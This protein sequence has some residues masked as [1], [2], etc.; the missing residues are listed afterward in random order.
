MEGEGECK[1]NVNRHDK[2][3]IENSLGIKKVPELT[4][5][6]NYNWPDESRAQPSFMGKYYAKLN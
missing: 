6:A 5:N 3:E 4:K 1:L 2:S